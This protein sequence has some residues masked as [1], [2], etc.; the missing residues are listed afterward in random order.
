[1]QEYLLRPPKR[2]RHVSPAESSELGNQRQ[3]VVPPLRPPTHQHAEA[4]S[5]PP[6]LAPVP[7]LQR[8]QFPQQKSPRPVQPPSTVPDG[9]YSPHMH[10]QSSRRPVIVS[11]S[12][13]AKNSDVSPLIQQ[14]TSGG[15]LEVTLSTPPTSSSAAS[16][17]SGVGS[18]SHRTSS[19]AE[20]SEV[21]HVSIKPIHAAVTSVGKGLQCTEE[22]PR[23]ARS[24]HCTSSRRMSYC[25]E[26][27]SQPLHP[28][29][30]SFLPREPASP[31]V[32]SREPPRWH[33][34]KWIQITLSQGSSPR[35][36]VSYNVY[37]N[38]F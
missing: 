20:Q 7:S 1:M 31:Y 22:R 26:Q 15:E 5:V 14:L 12:E 6:A 33:G 27:L 8:I 29:S 24:Q 10:H 30:S 16:S 11:A 35:I 28:E 36:L 23:D 19:D 25:V 13:L 17:D 2:A 37:Q 3:E 38:L 34:G 9:E 18:S 32:Y 4:L 21:M